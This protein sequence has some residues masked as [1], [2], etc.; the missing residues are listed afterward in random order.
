M[1]EIRKTLTLDN[2][3]GG[4]APE[5][6]QHELEKVLANIR[7]VNTPAKKARTI[8]LSIAFLPKEDRQGNRREMDVVVASRCSLAPV[9]QATSYAFIE[10]SGPSLK[11]TTDDYRQAELPLEPG[12]G[13]EVPLDSSDTAPVFA[14]GGV[15][16]IV[17][18]PEGVGRIA[19]DGGGISSSATPEG[20]TPL[21]G[22]RAA[23]P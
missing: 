3:G 20:V 13:G 23:A 11:A 2:V 7:D 6:F 17:A 22:P 19:L 14:P 21:H 8:T 4:A 18:A 10:G 1:P 9:K 5:L 12:P 15:G 16:R